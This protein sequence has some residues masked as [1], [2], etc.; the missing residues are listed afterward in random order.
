MHKWLWRMLAAFLI[1]PVAGAVGSA[2]DPGAISQASYVLKTATLGCAGSPGTSAGKQANGTLSQPTPVG[3]ALAAD[4][5][6]YAG[7]WSKHWILA[8]LEGDPYAHGLSDRLFQ[9]FPNPFSSRTTITYAEAQEGPV[10]ISVF[11]VEGRLVKTLMAQE[12]CPG[13]HRVVWDGR[14]ERGKPVSPG[15][16]FYRLRTP[17]YGSCKKMLK[18]K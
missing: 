16:Y 17:G 12:G 14:D 5:T 4:K 6:L 2:E 11:N 7:F 1:V 3:V 10:E 15:L 18:L 13:T 9:N 8:A